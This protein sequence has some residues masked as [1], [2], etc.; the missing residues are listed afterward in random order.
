ML[1]ILLSCLIMVSGNLFADQHTNI[2]SPFKLQVE[3][4]NCKGDSVTCKDFTN[5]P[6]FELNF[7][8]NILFLSDKDKSE[9]LSDP[10]I[11]NILKEKTNIKDEKINYVM[12]VYH[13]EGFILDLIFTG[14]ILENGLDIN[15]FE[16]R[17]NSQ[18]ISF[19]DLQ[20]K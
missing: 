20:L 12:S 6:V 4:V 17:M 11:V 18:R 7:E 3:I 9:L 1:K 19:A 15:K 5:D 14:E 10:S 2:Y 8:N 16:L 13:I